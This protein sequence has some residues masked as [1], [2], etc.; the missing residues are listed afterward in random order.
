M[1]SV[2]EGWLKVGQSMELEEI[3]KSWQ[4]G[5][6]WLVKLGDSQLGMSVRLEERSMELDDQYRMARGVS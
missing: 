4:V 1:A 3:I 2:F 5:G 6:E